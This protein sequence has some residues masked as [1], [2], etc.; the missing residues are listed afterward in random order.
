MDTA[1]III[2]A[3]I[4]FVIGI[5]LPAILSLV[6]ERIKRKDMLRERIKELRSEKILEADE[7][8]SYKVIS[9]ETLSRLVKHTVVYDI[10][11]NEAKALIYVGF[12][13]KVGSGYIVNEEI[14]SDYINRI[15]SIELREK[16][17]DESVTKYLMSRYGVANI[18]IY[19]ISREIGLK[20]LYMMADTKISDKIA[21]EP[22]F[23]DNLFMIG[24]ETTLNIEGTKVTIIPKDKHFFVIELLPNANPEHI[25]NAIK[26]LNI[27]DNIN[28]INQLRDMLISL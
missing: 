5:L 22:G 12:L 23:I 8:T 4:G 10:P 26:R 28:D 27:P 19:E 16:N 1:Q 21:R 13:T 17:L 20:M 15:K 6:W 7:N 9:P 14:V 11:E 2:Y 25:A 3:V 24:A 18:V